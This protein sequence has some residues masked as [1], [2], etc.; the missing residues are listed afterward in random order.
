MSTPDWYE[1][2]YWFDKEMRMGHMTEQYLSAWL[3]WVAA[4]EHAEASLTPPSQPEQVSNPPQYN[5]YDLEDHDWRGV[6]GSGWTE[7]RANARVFTDIK[8]PFNPRRFVFV[9]VNPPEVSK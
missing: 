9:L 5:L 2:Q 7:D 1:F 3:G 6:S 8:Q 4:T